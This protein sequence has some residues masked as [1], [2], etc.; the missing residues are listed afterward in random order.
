MCIDAALAA[1]LDKLSQLGMLA[2]IRNNVNG[3]VNIVHYKS[4]KS[5]RVCKSVLA[6]ELFAFVEGYH[7]GF[8]F[9]HTLGE[10]HGRKVHQTIY[11][12]S[13]SLYRLCIS[14]AH[15]TERRLQIDLALIREANEGKDITEIIRIV[16][17]QNHA[18]DLNKPTR[19]F[20]AMSELVATNYFAPTAQSWI[21]H[22]D[23]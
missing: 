19:R 3:K 14:A 7:V 23:I 16:G 15:T 17:K 9:A 11:T 10:L 6:A 2:M 12:D 8:T 1:N 22:D 13:Q 20:G 4:T 21:K 5:K 18:D